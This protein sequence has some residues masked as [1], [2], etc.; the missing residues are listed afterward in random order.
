MLLPATSQQHMPLLDADLVASSDCCKAVLVLI[1]RNFLQSRQG[2][3]QHSKAEN[4]LPA[5]QV[6][7][8]VDVPQ[9]QRRAVEPGVT[10]GTDAGLVAGCC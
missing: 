10:H 8:H 5:L 6:V 4:G 9:D 7:E 2:A 1:A 3:L